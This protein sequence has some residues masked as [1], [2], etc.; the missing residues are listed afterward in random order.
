M[1]EEEIEK[2]IDKFAP[3]PVIHDDRIEALIARTIAATNSAH[4][5][6][7]FGWLRWPTLLPVMQYAVPIAIAIL[8]G[9]QIGQNAENDAPVAQF[10]GL[11]M[12]STSLLPTGS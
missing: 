1:T 12:I 9:V 3:I 5:A 2:L 11:M 10:S 8:L 4:R 6:P 7:R